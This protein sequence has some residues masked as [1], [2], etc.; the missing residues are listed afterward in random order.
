[1]MPNTFK[2]TTIQRTNREWW[3]DVREGLQST[4]EARGKDTLVP[5]L[6]GEI[7]RN[8]KLGKRK[9]EL[10]G[11]VKG[12]SWSN[13]WTLVKE[14]LALFAPDGAAGT[15]SVPLD[16]GSTAT[17]SAQAVSVLPEGNEAIGAAR[18]FSVQLIAASPDWTEQHSG[19]ATVTHASATSA[20]GTNP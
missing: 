8:R 19:S 9:I 10:Y 13:Y 17:I 12:S 18:H 5:S 20:T 1:M 4:P 11:W 6:K 14:L 3:F 7:A 2:G 15:L 16:D